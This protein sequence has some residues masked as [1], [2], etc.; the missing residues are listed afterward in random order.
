MKKTTI[1]MAVAGAM[2]A[3]GSAFAEGVT[4]D[5]YAAV[6]WLLTNEADETQEGQFSVPETEVNFDTEHLFVAIAG[7]DEDD[8]FIRQAFL[9]YGITE[10]WD[11]KAGLFDSNLTADYATATDREF[12]QHSLL[13]SLLDSVGGASLKGVAVSGQLGMATVTLGYGNDS[14]VTPGGATDGENSMMLMVNASPMEGLDLELGVLTQDEDGAGVGNIIDIN[15]TYMINNFTVGL[16]YMSGSE[17]E[18]VFENGYSLWAGY[19]FGNGFGV[20]ARFEN[21]SA[22]GQDDTEATEL[23][24]SYALNDNLAVA[25]SLHN[26]DNGTTDADTNTI[27]LVGTF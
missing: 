13:F 11:L 3:A 1:A 18:T 16:D 20:K 22:D 2:F 12:V 26:L 21:A 4:V 24:A 19:D 25:V 9:K 5:G 15:G 6:N 14:S 17:N 23:Y 8:F 10:G 7:S 27:Q